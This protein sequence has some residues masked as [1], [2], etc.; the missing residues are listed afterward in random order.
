MTS[1]NEKSVGEWALIYQ[2]FLGG[3][4]PFHG[5]CSFL[6][7][8]RN[9]TSWTE[10]MDQIGLWF[11][12][13]MQYENRI[14]HHKQTYIERWK[15]LGVEKKC[16]ERKMFAWNFE[17]YF[18]MS[19]IM[20]TWWHNT[21]SESYSIDPWATWLRTTFSGF[22][23][24]EAGTFVSILCFWNG[25]NPN[26]VIYSFSFLVVV[27]QVCSIGFVISVNFEYVLVVVSY[28]LAKHQ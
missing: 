23:R 26:D 18:C 13:K 14:S 9:A 5:G 20:E 10:L 17:I 2:L 7:F 24:V 21:R 15:C 12:L 11:W 3:A 25:R 19:Y 27:Y 22:C 28:L 16:A 6:Y 8:P 1:T 4:A